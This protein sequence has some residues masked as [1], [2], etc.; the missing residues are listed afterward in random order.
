MTR[1]KICGLTRREDIESVNRW[2]PDYIGFVFC[3]SRRQVTAEQ[4]GRLKAAL[5]SRI[6]AVGV[7]VNAPAGSIVNLCTSRVIDLVQLHGDENE[8]YVEELKHKIDCPLIKAVRV[9]SPAQVLQAEQLPCDL[10]LLD[11]YQKD[12]YGGSGKSFDYAMIPAL[13][14]PFILAGGLEGSSII[15]AIGR[16]RPYGVDV[17]SGVETDGVKDD[18]KIKAIIRN[19][20]NFR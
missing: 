15:Q 5:D 16:C 14:K 13:K 20:R 17:S 1:I 3:P 7:F 2:L 18:V 10:L 8:G 6:K 9:Q 12:Q 11:A 4:A 19:V